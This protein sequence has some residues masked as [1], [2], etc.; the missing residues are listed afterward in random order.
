MRKEENFKKN[1][2]SLFNEA[3]D[4]ESTP[5]LNSLKAQHEHFADISKYSE[6]GLKIIHLCH[7][8]RT[9]RRV[10]MA[11][12]KDDHDPQKV[13]AFIRE[14]KLNAALQHPN[15]VPV[16]EIG[17]DDESPW[18]TMKFIAGRSLE[19]LLDE[20]LDNKENELSDLNS[21]LDVFIKICDAISY[22]HSL[23]VL[24]L[25]IKPANIRI[26]NYGDVVVCDWGLADVISSECD[27][28]LLEYCSLVE[29]DL[30]TLTVDGN[31]KGTLGYMSPEQTSKTKVRKGT[32]TDVFSLGAVLY[33]LL[34]FHKAF[35]GKSFTEVI[36]KT[37]KCDFPRPS[38][39]SPEVPQSLEAVC[40]KAMSLNIEDRYTTV[41]DLKKEIVNYRNGF[42]TNAENASLLKALQLFY[43]RHKTVS[44]I[45]SFTLILI[46]VLGVLALNH[47]SLTRKNAIQ[48]AEKLSIE[49]EY[50]R[51]INKDAAPL[52][53][54]NAKAA[55]KGNALDDCLNFCKSVTELDESILE[56]WELK[57]KV[58]FVYGDLEKSA[59]AFRNAKIKTELSELATEYLTKVPKVDKLKIEDYLR[60]M[61]AAFSI[62]D[63]DVF[64][65]M[66]N[67]QCFSKELSL[68][69]RVTFVKGEIR[70][71]HYRKMKNEK[72][73]F[74][75]DPETGHLDLSD[76]KWLNT[77]LCLQNFPAKSVDLSN[78]SVT[79]GIGLRA[80][81]LESL[82]I[83]HTNMIE[84][85]SL[86]CDGLKE[87]IV[88][89][90]G[91]S[92]LSPIAHFPIEKLDIRNTG[93]RNLRSLSLFKKLKVV[94]VSTLQFGKD[95][96]KKIPSH[97]KVIV[98]AK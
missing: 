97:I 96:L 77:V 25:D 60:L 39:Y 48:L 12:L 38:F 18:F 23:G 43:L 46:I 44:L 93:V 83:S 92:N 76:N 69:D 30:T 26:S 31:V 36:D 35:T 87:L 85:Q 4:V 19:E 3:Y 75:F 95:E 79:N 21:R 62:R 82:N 56:A 59:E 24:H 68:E 40:L 98:G 22:A 32:H 8:C 16:Y 54:E 42:A 71:R 73:M 61:K 80:Q 91:V 9:N 13:E 41:A 50:H 63:F 10:A 70:I 20:L 94:H 17:I 90:T 29:Y 51:K 64:G 57:A 49:A 37:A 27:E 6:G 78:T 86:E 89:N 7:D 5:L 2:G 1:I 65:K 14:A 34:T 58:Y 81:T 33:S 67:Y 66:T 53:L 74:K 52:F 15:I 72:F 47:L 11:T 28:S 45:S 88:A 55:F 84:L